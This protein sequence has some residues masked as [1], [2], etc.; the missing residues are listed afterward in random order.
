[1]NQE[2]DDAKQ[3]KRKYVSM[4]LRTPELPDS[5]LSSAEVNRCFGRIYHLRLRSACHLLLAGFLL[6]L[7][8]IMTMERMFLLM[9]SFFP[10]HMTL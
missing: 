6:S 4:V 7:L 3:P 2:A 10:K 1:M 5:L 8:S 9:P